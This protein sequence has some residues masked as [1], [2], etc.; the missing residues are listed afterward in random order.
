MQE[1]VEQYHAEKAKADAAAAALLAELDEEEAAKSKRMLTIPR[2]N[3]NTT[4]GLT[5]QCFRPKFLLKR[6]R[7]H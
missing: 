5:Q 1:R 6:W 4:L 7:Q 3:I 2:K